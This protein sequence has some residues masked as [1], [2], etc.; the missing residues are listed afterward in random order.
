MNIYF[1]HKDCLLRGYLS[2]S[3]L[4]HKRGKRATKGEGKK[5]GENNGISTKENQGI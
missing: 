3:F 4:I 5:E 2:L 1:Q